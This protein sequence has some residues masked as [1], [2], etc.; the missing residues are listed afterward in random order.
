MKWKWLKK[1]WCADG[2]GMDVLISG[3]GCVYNVAGSAVHW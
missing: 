3:C 1:A 2:Y